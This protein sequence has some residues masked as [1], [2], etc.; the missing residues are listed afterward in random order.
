M[1]L[2]ASVLALGV[3]TKLNTARPLGKSSLALLL[4][5]ARL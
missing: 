5:I 3:P 2:L 1:R 4:R